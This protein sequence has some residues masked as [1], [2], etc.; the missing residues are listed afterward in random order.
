MRFP[1]PPNPSHLFSLLS[2]CTCLDPAHE[3]PPTVFPDVVGLINKLSGSNVL[4]HSI[5]APAAVLRLVKAK[6]YAPE[7]LYWDSGALITVLTGAAVDPVRSKMI[8]GGVYE[9]HFIVCELT[10]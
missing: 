9:R 5:T 1:P 4:D 3:C 7:V 8:A 6:D 2:I 10:E